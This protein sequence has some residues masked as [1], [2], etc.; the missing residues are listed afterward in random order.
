[1]HMCMTRV[2]MKTPGG[3][4]YAHGLKSSR[5]VCIA[6]TTWNKRGTT[7][8]NIFS[9]VNM[10]KRYGT[11][12]EGSYTAHNYMW[13]SMSCPA[14]HVFIWTKYVIEWFHM[15]SCWTKHTTTCEYLLRTCEMSCRV[16]LHMCFNGLNVWSSNF[17][18]ECCDHLKQRTQPHV[19]LSSAQVEYDVM[20]NNTRTPAVLVT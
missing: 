2:H 5:Q 6:E 18:C 7:C 16:K 10:W 20:S 19:N 8:E 1:M 14:T 13:N 15:W 12:C 3:P 4:C 9:R 11:T 17:T